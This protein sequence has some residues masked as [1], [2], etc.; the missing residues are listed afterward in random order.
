[1]DIITV[2]ECCGGQRVHRGDFEYISAAVNLLLFE[3]IAVRKFSRSYEVPPFDH[4][5]QA[6]DS[7][8]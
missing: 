3:P 5:R 4:S 8:G 6:Q 7:R 2:E 1:M